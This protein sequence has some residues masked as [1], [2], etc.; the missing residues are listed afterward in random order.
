MNA[1]MTCLASR[2]LLG[3]SMN[4]YYTRSLSEGPPKTPKYAKALEGWR[5]DKGALSPHANSIDA[6]VGALSMFLVPAERSEI[7][8]NRRGNLP[9]PPATCPVGVLSSG[10]STAR[11]GTPVVLG[12]DIGPRLPA[13]SR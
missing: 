6:I 4:L 9:T 11:T 12:L 2:P 7:A 5:R 3:I 13:P 10:G 1:P 8:R